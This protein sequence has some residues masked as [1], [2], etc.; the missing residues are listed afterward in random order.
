MK[1][2]KKINL[3]GIFFC[4][5]VFTNFTKAQSL[6]TLSTLTDS[7]MTLQQQSRKAKF[8]NSEFTESLMV[9]HVGDLP[10]LQNDGVVSLEIPG[11]SIEHDFRGKYVETLHNG[12]FN[13]NGDLITRM[14]C[15]IEKTEVDDCYDGDLT[16]LKRGDA[17]FGEIR[18]NETVYQIRD[19]KGGVNALVKLD[20]DAFLGIYCD[21][22]GGFLSENATGSNNPVNTAVNSELNEASN[23]LL[24]ISN[25]SA[26]QKAEPATCPVKCLVLYTEAALAKYPDIENIAEIS[27]FNT[28]VAIKNSKVNNLELELV[29]IIPLNNSIFEEG[30]DHIVDIDNIR[31]DPTIAT[32][33]ADNF[34]D[35]VIVLT[36]DVYSVGGVVAK[37]GESSDDVDFAFGLVEAGSSNGKYLVFG[38]E[39][40]HLFGCHHHLESN[41]TTGFD[42]TGT[43]Y[44][45]GYVVSKGCNCLF[46]SKK[47]RITI[48]SPCTPVTALKSFSTPKIKWKNKRTGTSD[49]NDNARKLEEEA[50]RVANYV[51]GESPNV[52]INGPMQGCPNDVVTFGAVITG[53]P[54]P[55]AYEWRISYDGF[56]FGGVVSTSSTV[57]VTLGS[58]IGSYVYVKLTAGNVNGP[59]ITKTKSAQITNGDDD[60]PC[61]LNL[62]NMIG[63]DDDNQIFV[64]N[65]LSVF[66]NPANQ[67][68]NIGLPILQEGSV[69]ITLTNHLGLKVKE[70]KITEIE[71]KL[72]MNVDDIITG[73]YWLS[74]QH[75]DYRETIKV[76]IMK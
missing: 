61:N 45:H 73:I 23:N 55:F 20:N 7:Q 75:K 43:A 62:L 39:V 41:C 30:V 46:T 54:P 49:K 25:N 50:C 13:W 47:R 51:Y 27:L 2:M 16:V 48:M 26:E 36:D 57:S 40:G 5:M 66:P 9:V 24:P 4:L 74:V 3:A 68:L 37:V 34:A 15:D 33:R 35:I 21:S 8:E 28:N 38:H 60:F 17:V 65:K 63:N 71:R 64:E 19:L 29:D 67:Q 42:N 12:D 58:T 18:I 72:E 1:K 22:G 56:N 6:L 69:A 10:N 44:A 32:Y 52:S 31:T 59:F 11:I 76:S 14:Y 53:T 70:I